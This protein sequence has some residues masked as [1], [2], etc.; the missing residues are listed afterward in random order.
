MN[1]KLA[2]SGL[3]SAALLVGCGSAPKLTT[4]EGEWED[5]PFTHAPKSRIEPVVLTVPAPVAEPVQPLITSEVPAAAS[6]KVHRV[7][8]KAPKPLASPVAAPP[9]ASDQDY[10]CTTD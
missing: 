4:P 5:L 7:R 8:K 1:I 9:A 2:L 6:P 3:L 10:K